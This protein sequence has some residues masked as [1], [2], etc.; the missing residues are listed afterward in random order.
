MIYCV[1]C[2]QHTGETDLTPHISKNG[3]PMVKGKCDIC[4]IIK[5]K[6]VSNNEVKEGGSLATLFRGLLPLIKTAVP[7]VL[8]TVIPTLGLSAI[9]GAVSGATRKRVEG[10]GRRRKKVTD[11]MIRKYAR[12]NGYG[13]IKKGSG[14]WSFIKGIFT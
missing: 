6:F 12:D 14:I 1:K 5:N 3:R 9:S 11:E 8:K 7:K 10:T 13:E 4:G 2:K